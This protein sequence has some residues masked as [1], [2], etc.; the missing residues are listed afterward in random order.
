MIVGLVGASRAQFCA[1]G[2]AFTQTLGQTPS[3][4]GRQF[5]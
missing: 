2:A 3:I 1:K 4:L 5:V